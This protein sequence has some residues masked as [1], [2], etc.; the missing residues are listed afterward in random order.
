MDD[1]RIKLSALWVARM[2]TGLQGDVVRFMEPGMMQQIAAGGV[3]GM[4]LSDALLFVASAVMLFPIAMVVLSLT[5]P[6][7]WCR[8]ANVSLAAFFVAFDLV[9]LPTYGSAHGIALIAA[10]IAFNLATAWYAWTWRTADRPARALEAR[11]T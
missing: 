4:P 3:D 11:R 6:Y 7:R 2:L 1:V 10:G 5:L 9:G 8:W